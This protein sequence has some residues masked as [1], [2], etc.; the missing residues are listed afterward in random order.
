MTFSMHETMGDFLP[1][2]DLE[3]L[4]PVCNTQ[5]TV[6]SCVSHIEHLKAIYPLNYA[7]R[8]FQEEDSDQG[9]EAITMSIGDWHERIAPVEK[10]PASSESVE[11]NI[12]E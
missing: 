6:S 11:A 2:T 5:T 7:K 9:V 1:A 10:R 8:K 4:W 12:H 3:V